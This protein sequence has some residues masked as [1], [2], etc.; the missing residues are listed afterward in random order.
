[1]HQ[2]RAFP[3]ERLW[4]TAWISRFDNDYRHVPYLAL[5]AKL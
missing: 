2:R 1:M 3:R 5:G 4:I